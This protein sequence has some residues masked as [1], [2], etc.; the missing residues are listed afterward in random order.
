M[1]G[2]PSYWIDPIIPASQARLRAIRQ[3][4][5]GLGFK[6]TEANPVTIVASQ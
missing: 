1:D 3:H 2:E 4:L 6:S 5:I